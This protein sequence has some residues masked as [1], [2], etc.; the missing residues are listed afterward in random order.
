MKII[1]NNRDKNVNEKF[2]KSDF[3]NIMKQILDKNKRHKLNDF[4]ND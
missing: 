4:N 1:F 2:L 3:D